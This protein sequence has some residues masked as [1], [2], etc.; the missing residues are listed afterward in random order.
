MDP[1]NS[2][3]PTMPPMPDTSSAQP[4]KTSGFDVAAVTVN[5]TEEHKK[6]PFPKAFLILG[7]V[8]IVLIFGVVWLLNN[9]GGGISTAQNRGEAAGAGGMA[10]RGPIPTVDPSSSYLT[11]ATAETVVPVN[12]EIKLMIKANSQGVDVSGYDLLIPYDKNMF[13]I[14]GA[15]SKQEAFQIYQFD[16]GDYYSITGI[17]LLNVTDPTPFADSD[18]IELTIVPKQKGALYI[19]VISEKGKET[20]KFVDSEVKVIKPQFQPIKL[21]IQ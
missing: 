5:Q 6:K 9:R 19:E 7:V 18:I 14:K 3:K 15:V 21:E 11:F 4:A 16:R 10:D 13:K 20:S 1:N 8:V 17:K 2:A 12:Q